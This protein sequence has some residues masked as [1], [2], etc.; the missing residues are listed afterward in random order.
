MAIDE[1]MRTETLAHSAA[2]Q[3]LLPAPTMGNFPQLGV[4]GARVRQAKVDV[5]S[6][7]IC[8]FKRT[9]TTAE[10]Q[11]LDPQAVALGLNS[12]PASSRRPF[13]D[14]LQS[15]PSR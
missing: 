12:P 14:A 6:L 15:D 2:R 4:D 11:Q 10:R 7:P 8:W 5:S 13:I 1:C 3:M 9:D